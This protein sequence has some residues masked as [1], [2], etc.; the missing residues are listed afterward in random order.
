[1]EAPY[2]NIFG[3]Q[4]EA[5][6]EGQLAKQNAIGF[7]ESSMKE[8]LSQFIRSNQSI[9]HGIERNLI[10]NLFKSRPLLARAMGRGKGRAKSRQRKSFDG[11]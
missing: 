6:P 11:L 10:K 1:M 7:C 8:G 3:N 9:S 2:V 5:T 4:T